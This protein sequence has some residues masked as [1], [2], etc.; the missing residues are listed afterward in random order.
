M[1][2]AAYS[3]EIKRVGKVPLSS[4]IFQ[5]F[6]G[7][8]NSHKDF[9]FGTFILLYYS[10]VL[11]LSA[12]LVSVVIG[13]SLIVDAISDPVVGSISDSFKSKLGRRHP[14]MLASA[15]P[16]GITMYLLFVPPDGISDNLLLAW[17]L[18]FT[19]L[20]RLAF[21][22]FI[23]PWNALAAEF[24][25]DYVERTS[26][27]TFR[28]LVGW[29]GG[30]TFY[31]FTWQYIFYNTEA[32]PAGQL[33]PDHY[34]NF[35]IIVGVLVTVWALV[36]TLGTRKEIPYILQPTQPTPR[37]SFTRVLE[38]VLLALTNANFRRLFILSLLFSGIAGIGGV[39]DIYMNTYFW[40][41][42]PPELRWFAFAGVG[43]MAAFLSVPLLQIRFDKQTLLQ[44]C[45]S[46]VMVF[47]ILKVTLRFADVLPE[48]GDPLLLWFLVLHSIAQTYLLTICGIMVASL[49]ADML[50]EQEL[51]T[52]KRQEGVFSAALSFSSKA[53]S[54]VGIIMGGFLLDYVIS[55][56]KQAA[57][58][59]IEY[60]TLFRL[61]FTDGVA[62]PLLFF[63]PIYLISRVTITRKRLSEIQS[64]LAVKRG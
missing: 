40:E 2:D 14:F 47:A 57:P 33:N 6:G 3:R 24:S 51:F 20:A 31:L 17:L 50:D 36:S 37:L 5:G 7:L 45:L 60:E 26:I 54:S 11:G 59:T 44:W 42:T 64:E 30:I 61:A 25:E 58:G 43:A 53:T 16:F 23:V 39:F 46:I 55:L 49:V 34:Q 1:T 15:I 18:V 63:I 38:E 4:K 28:Y 21:T 29:I 19:V 13:I 8:V 48:N 62:I 56:P 9:A 22:F 41:L 27:I 52:G 10:Q 32:Y 12:S 35:G